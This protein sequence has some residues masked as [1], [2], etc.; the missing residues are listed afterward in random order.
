MVLI[1]TEFD[2]ASGSAPRLFV[3]PWRDAELADAEWDTLAA[4]AAEPNPF[5]ERP[6]LC[7]SLEAFDP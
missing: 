3:A 6:F 1:D 2:D 4:S 5:F 7:A